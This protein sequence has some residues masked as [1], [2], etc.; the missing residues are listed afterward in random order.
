MARSSLTTKDMAKSDS[1][2]LLSK[3]ARFVR[4]PMK[5]WSEFDR[6]EP[7]PESGY[8]KEALKE[9]IERKRQNDFVRKREFDQLRKMRRR[10][11]LVNSDQ[12]GRPSFFQS[13]LPSNPD[14]RAMTLR[15]IDEIEAQMSRQWWKGRQDEA[16]ARA[17]NLPVPARTPTNAGMLIPA[18]QA[19]DDS[20]FKQTE[21]SAYRTSLRWMESS[22]EFSSTQMDQTGTTVSGAIHLAQSGAQ[23]L[24]RPPRGEWRSGNDWDAVDLCTDRWS[25]FF[26]L[27]TIC[28][29]VG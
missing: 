5:D 29:G 23:P 10:E 15:K 3:V 28:R 20:K 4:N 25:R 12:A 27:E 26:N 24:S 18:P 22:G 13:S 9:M 17:S 8:S 7:A 11:P 6:K 14:E 1:P 16:S 2:G 21:A 19:E